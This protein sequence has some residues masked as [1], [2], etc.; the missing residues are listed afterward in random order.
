MRKKMEQ[1]CISACYRAFWTFQD[2]S[3]VSYWL[4]RLSVENQAEEVTRIGLN[5]GGLTRQDA[6]PLRR[7]SVG[8]VYVSLERQVFNW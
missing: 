6:V 3:S 4:L 1:N 7:T 8:T 5:H 2:N